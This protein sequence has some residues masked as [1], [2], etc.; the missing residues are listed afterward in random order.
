MAHTSAPEFSELLQ[1]PIGP[2]A[3]CKHF[4]SSSEVLTFIQHIL[5]YLWLSLPLADVCL[6]SYSLQVTISVRGCIIVC[7]G[8]N[9][10]SPLQVNSSRPCTEVPDT[11]FYHGSVST[12]YEH[13]DALHLT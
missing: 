8:I 4:K 13:R 1:L 10:T 5:Q 6:L 2:V 12:L 3:A 7:H 9:P 11:G